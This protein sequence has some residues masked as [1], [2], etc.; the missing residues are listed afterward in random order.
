MTSRTR[1][2]LVDD[3]PFTRMMLA[4]VLTNLSY[5]VIGAA[6]SAPSAM[7][8][9]RELKPD[10][11]VVDLD[12]GEGPT[13]VDLAH[14]LRM[15]LPAIGI[16]ML[17]TYAEPRLLSPNQNSLPTGSLYVVKNTV[18]EPGVLERALQLS[19]DPLVQDGTLSLTATQQE[20]AA[21]LLTDLQIN[22][23][24]MVAAGYSNAEIAR[25]R[26]ITVSS[27]EKAVARLIRQLNLRATLDQNQR[28]MIAKIYHQLTGAKDV[29]GS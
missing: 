3:D 23:M 18:V 13:G 10:I 1:L 9:A 6:P 4:S 2:I 20:N 26:S 16:V 21:D 7:R 11:A 29:R 24:R 8:I 15:L 19:V 12:L 17:S 22:L 27:V 14:G 28:V 5:D 25:R